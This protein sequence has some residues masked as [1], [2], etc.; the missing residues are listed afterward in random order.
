MEAGRRQYFG[1]IETTHPDRISI[2]RNMETPI[3]SE[4]GE[5]VNLRD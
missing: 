4:N 5:Y 1:G 2:Q 3:G